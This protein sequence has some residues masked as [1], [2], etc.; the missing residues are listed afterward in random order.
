MITYA[1]SLLIGLFKQRLLTANFLASQAPLLDVYNAA[2]ALPDTLFQ[3]LVVGSLSAGFIPIFNRYAAKSESEAYKMA[4]SALNLLLVIFTVLTA[5]VF[6]FAPSFSRLTAPGFDA[7]QIIL[8]AK[9]LRIMMVAQLFFCV[10]G[11]LT[12]I[13]QSHQR[14]LVPAIAPIIYNL[15]II[16]GIV[17][18]SPSMGVFG[19]AYGVVIGSV[20]HMLIQLPLARTLGF[21]FQ[22]VFN[23]SH[24]GVVEIIR[25]MPPRAL[26]LGV[27][28][29]EQFVAITLA[30][31]L[32]AGS[33][34]LF[35]VAF[36]LY[37]LPTT[38]FGL[39]MGQ[40]ALPQL[41]KEAAL[42]DLTS[43]WATIR[44]TLLQIAFFALPV[45]ALL[46]VLRIP[47][48]RLVF[49]S[50]TF[51]WEAT[52]LTGETAAILI[53]SAFA[54]SCMQVVIRGF[55]ALHDTT[56]PLYVGL[57]A[58]IFNIGFGFAASQT[59]GFGIVGIAAAI[60][61]TSIIESTALFLLLARKVTGVSNKISSLAMPLVKMLTISLITG[62]TLWRLMLFLDTILD[63]SR[64]ISLGIL[65]VITSVL[66][67]G[68]YLLL[69]YALHLE[70]LATVVQLLRR[71]SDWRSFFTVKPIEPII[72]PPADQD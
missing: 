57:F 21:R 9:L 61:I 48:V 17:L 31:L 54:A 42:S 3:I 25:C 32:T 24:P 55:Y 15:S 1:L 22:L 50:A 39:T 30:S 68:L 34:S 13:I 64:T 41:S 12:G 26:A 43:Y 16:L 45:S 14:F 47:I 36:T 11:F 23:P 59:F 40:A 10:S 65:T 62:I 38:L 8:M 4:A 6:I 20:L 37:T 29:I 72:S 49:G 7:A 51:P 53:L 33:I 60:S 58:A 52:L 70:Q 69:S 28:Q 5:I 66:G 63:T 19:P 2:F 71:L 18:L 44:S 67:L 46:I 27:D 56:T 35:R